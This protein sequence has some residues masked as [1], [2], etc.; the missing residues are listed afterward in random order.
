[1]SSTTPVT[2]SNSGGALPSPLVAN[3][4]YYARKVDANTL[5]LHTTAAGSEGNTSRVNLTDNGTG[6]QTLEFRLFHV[7]HSDWFTCD[8]D[9]LSD[10]TSDEATIVV[11]RDI[12]YLHSTKLLPPFDLSVVPSPA[13]NSTPTEY[14]PGIIGSFKASLNTA[15]G[16]NHRGYLP[17]WGINTFLTQDVG[18][19]QESRV[20]ALVQA[21]MPVM[22]L[23]EATGKIPALRGT[24]ATGDTGNYT[25]LGTSIPTAHYFSWTNN[26]GV[27]APPS[28]S[29]GGWLEG[30]TGLNWSHQPEG[31]WYPTLTE[32]GCHLMDASIT[33]VNQALLCTLASST[34]TGIPNSQTRRH[35][36]TSG[37]D[38]N[39][40]LL[41]TNNGGER[42]IGWKMR[43]WNWT[44]AICPD[45]W[46]EKPYLMDVLNLTAA[47]SVDQIIPGFNAGFQ[48]TGNWNF[49]AGFHWGNPWMQ[50]FITSSVAHC[51]ALHESAD[52]LA[53]V[54]HLKKQVIGMCGGEMECAFAGTSFTQLQNPTTKTLSNYFDWDEMA[55]THTNGLTSHTLEYV[56]AAGAPGT[57]TFTRHTADTTQ[58]PLTAGDKLKWT[59]MGAGAGVNT[60]PGGIVAGQWYY[61]INPS[62]STGQDLTF[63]VSE[64]EGGSAI[65]VSSNGGDCNVGWRSKQV[66]PTVD[67]TAT[68]TDT[69]LNQAV[70][71]LAYLKACGITGADDAYTDMLAFQGANFSTFPTWALQDS[72]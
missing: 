6:T 53:W 26:S 32:G 70:A 25:G 21:G 17:V 1:L 50:H 22:W 13:T 24:S 16:S 29:E 7:H 66:C 60:L 48:N 36:I 69:T 30:G 41:C 23:N 10:W 34:I 8:L 31:F 62:G 33:M 39:Y 46:D 15:G 58:W 64:T 49:N 3:T 19:I 63:Q 12:V 56:R 44:A 55:F 67:N 65:S 61:V 57:A 42:V 28:T 52:L 54:D 38:T 4:V 27:Q 59:T 51:Y 40:G 5:T 68:Q 14:R 20:N 71:C 47:H 72:F 2:V 9:G 43:S 35:R 45:D 37:H 18:Y 11:T